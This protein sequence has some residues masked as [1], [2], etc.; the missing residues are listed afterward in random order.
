MCDILYNSPKKLSSSR[1][2]ALSFVLSRPISW[3]SDRIRVFSFLLSGIE[4]P[5]AK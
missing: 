3:D 2:L 5:K 1:A 4:F